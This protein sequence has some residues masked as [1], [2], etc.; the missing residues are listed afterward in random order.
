[1]FIVNQVEIPVT[2]VIYFQLT[3]QSVK[4]YNRG[5][6]YLNDLASREGVPLFEDIQEAVN[7]VI[8]MLTDQSPCQ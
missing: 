4:D 7:C 8:F 3:E 6:E 1:M 5:R 2:I